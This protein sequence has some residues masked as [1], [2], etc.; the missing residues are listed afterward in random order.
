M[1][2]SPVRGSSLSTDVNT[3]GSDAP[4]A[5]VRSHDANPGANFDSARGDSLAS[6]GEAS[7]RCR[8]DLDGRR[9]LKLRNDRIALNA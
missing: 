4:I 2:W 5:V 1:I 3:G 6:L 8:V 9:I 7:T